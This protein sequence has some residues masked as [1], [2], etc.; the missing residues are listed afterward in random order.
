MSLRV[1]ISKYYKGFDLKVSF[2]T[3]GTS[4]GLL[5]ASGCGKSLT[6]KCIAGIVM[7][8]E[9]EIILNDR[10]LFDSRKKIA[11]APK[12]RRVGLMFQNYAL[13]PN[14]TVRE[15]IETGL[16][17]E[18]NRASI[19]GNL[20]MM[21]RL[22]GKL[23]RYPYQLSG[24]EQQRV[25]LARMLAN[26]PEVLL[27]DEPFSALDAFL[28][29]QLQQEL[30]E[31][32]Q[33]FH[34]DILMVSHNREEIYRFCKKI[35]V[36]N[37]GRVIESGDKTEVFGNPARLTTAKLTGCKN[38]SGARK[39][40]EYSLEAL[41]W[42]MRL[43]TD[44]PVNDKVSF[45]GIRAHNLRPAGEGEKE[46]TLSV[47]RAQRSEGPFEDRYILRCGDTDQ[48]ACELNWIIARREWFS[49]LK[50]QIPSRITLPAESLLLLTE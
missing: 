20:V 24:G 44:R 38:I 12:D 41:D 3:E 18:E 37:K 8:D 27:F 39:L 15:N 22:E 4:L 21:L 31:G 17:R 19:I 25:A 33:D 46:N 35:V 47:L 42:N 45:V 50:E 11:L 36:V 13:F 29:D 1:N 16:R 23:Q 28:K 34:G 48:T 9:G 2:D 5:G 32:L 49:V 26:E 40:S 7:P 10:I 14:M 6:L 30:L 43:V